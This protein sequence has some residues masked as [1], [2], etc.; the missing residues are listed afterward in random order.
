MPNLILNFKQKKRMLITVLAVLFLNTLHAQNRILISYNEKINLGKV[1][2]NTHFYFSNESEN[3]RLKGNEINNYTF[4]KPGVYTLKVEE[5]EMHQQGSCTDL[6]LP[7]EILVEV[8]R[9]KMV[10]DSNSISF[11]SPIIKNKNT[12]GITLNITVTIETYDHLPASL[13]M[14]PIQTAGIGT[15]IIATLD[16]KFKELPE[17]KHTLQ[18]ALSGIVIE[19]SYLMFDFEDANGKIQSVSLTTPVIN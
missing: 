16:A 10:F 4:S 18:Y 13:I 19:N 7:K 2:K 8:S 9:I 14:K 5:K 12:E 17:G 1:S 3:I 11:S 15:N 6:H